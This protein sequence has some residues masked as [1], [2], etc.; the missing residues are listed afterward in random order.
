MCVLVRIH[1]CFISIFSLLIVCPFF[2]M[3]VYTLRAQGEYKMNEYL[4]N[5]NVFLF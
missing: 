2:E 4:V 5:E 1:V 3:Y